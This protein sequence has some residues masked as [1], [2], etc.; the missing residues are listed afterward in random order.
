MKMKELFEKYMT[1]QLTHQDLEV[2]RSQPKASTDAELEEFMKN[3]WMDEDI[4]TSRVSDELQDKVKTNIYRQ[5]APVHNKI[6]LYIKVLG[7]AAAILL[8][9]LLI[10]TLYYYHESDQVTSQEMVVTTGEGE[11]ATISLPDGTK[12]TLNSE[13]RLGYIPKTFNKEKRQINFSG[14]GYFVVAKNEECPFMI[15]ARGLNVKVLGTTFNLSVR[16]KEETAQLALEEG[17][18]WFKSL[19]SGKSVILLPNQKL[20]MNQN[21]G[22]I[23]VV[24]ESVENISAW[25]RNEMIFNNATL[26]SVL[27]SI[28]KTYNVRIDMK[29]R[30]D[31]TDLFTGTLSTNDIYG[32]LEVLE[33]SY[34]L[35]ATMK[36]KNIY[37][38]RRN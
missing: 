22:K 13:S 25:K 35:K 34:H 33:K 16:D 2:L 10:S 29:G 9:V 12:V 37:I 26:T 15:D 23:T 4:N 6:P 11:K 28:E 38:V 7:W 5:M 1:N 17:K 21:T 27:Q 36:G 32:V 3:K 14:E 18:V 19:V 30:E 20:T 8:P 31:T 24:N